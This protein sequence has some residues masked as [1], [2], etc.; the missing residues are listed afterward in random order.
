MNYVSNYIK[1]INML[2]PLIIEQDMD[3]PG[4]NFDPE[5]GVFELTGKSFPADVAEF[6]EPLLE[7]IDEYLLAP[8]EE[9]ILKIKLDYFNTASSKVLLEIFYKF[10]AHHR[11]GGNVICNWYYP[12]DD[13]DMEET[14]IEY[15]EIVNIPFE[16]IGYTV[17]LK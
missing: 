17:V 6:Y 8:A 2:Q 3:T 9:N 7:W 15:S 4:I 1:E 13:E 11:N 5:N 14:G 16:Q 10:E 12:D